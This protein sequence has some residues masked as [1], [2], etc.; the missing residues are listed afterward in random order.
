MI[1]F[2]IHELITSSECFVPDSFCVVDQDRIISRQT[3]ESLSNLIYERIRSF[4]HRHTFSLMAIDNSALLV[5]A[6]VAASKHQLVSV[7]V[8]PNTSAVR[9][10]NIID[11]VK[12]RLAFTLSPTREFIDVLN[13]KRI[14]MID[15]ASIPT[16]HRA[17]AFAACGS[18]QGI[19]TDPAIGMLTSGTSG[20]GIKVACMSHNAIIGVSESIARY[21][22]INSRDRILMLP[23]SSFDYGLYQIFIASVRGA[24]IIIPPTNVRKYSGELRTFIEQFDISVLPFTPSVARLHMK[25]WRRS[26][27]TMPSVRLITF[28]GSRFPNDLV[29]DLKVIFPNARVV[30]MYG[31]TEAKRCTFLPEK[32]YPSKLPSVGIPIPNTR[33]RV[34]DSDGNECSAFQEGEVEICGR[35]IM[36]GYHD[37]DVSSSVKIIGLGLNRRLLTGD[38]GYTDNDGLLYLNGRRDDVVKINDHRVSLRNIESVMLTI[39][40]ITE[41]AITFSDACGI[42]AHIVSRC[43]VSDDDINNTV[44]TYFGE[45]VFIPRRIIR[46]SHIP[47]T[48]AGKIDY[49]KL[50]SELE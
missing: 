42:T 13:N 33:I 45:P 10:G 5:P 17:M 11:G 16:S 35:N 37:L 27:T 41:C 1:P 3:V 36:N 4:P 9:L 2:L 15:I 28:T 8:S 24:T 12:A 49:I 39:E 46:V 25:F 34:V 43:E 21:L 38:V 31:I 48:E 32:F 6:L 23:P 7:P 18:E 44:L 20:G 30:P 19:D 47:L 40:A 26:D 29:N 22:A 14:Q 50:S